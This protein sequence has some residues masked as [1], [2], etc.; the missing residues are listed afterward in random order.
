VNLPGMPHLDTYD[1]VAAD[2]P[3]EHDNFGQ[4]KHGAA[5][6]SYDEMPL[7]SVEED[8]QVAGWWVW[9]LSCWIGGGW[10][11]VGMANG[12]VPSEQAK[13]PDL[14]RR[15][16]CSPD[17]VSPS[18][19]R[20]NCPPVGRRVAVGRTGVHRVCGSRSG[21]WATRA[22]ID[23]RQAA[24]A[25]RAR[26]AARTWAAWAEARASSRPTIT[27]EETGL[28]EWFQDLARASD[29]SACAAATG[30]A[31]SRR[32]C[33]SPRRA[34]RD[35]PRPALRPGRARRQPLLGGERRASPPTFAPGRSST[36]RTSTSASC[37]AA[38]RASTTCPRAGASPSGTRAAATRAPSAASR[39]ASESA[40]GSRPH[41]YLLVR[42]GFDRKRIESGSLWDADHIEARVYGGATTLANARTLCVPCH[43][44]V[45]AELAR[46][47]AASRRRWR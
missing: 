31:S 34:D 22:C 29:A 11:A 39:T 36:A 43:R 40:C 44:S 9:G 13:K 41:A 18:V 35:R 19:W 37:S 38:T 27:R 30:S 45:T 12:E 20:K 33:S 24:R 47:R 42:A 32:R 5:K 16:G 10:C 23:E 1:I 46:S 17:V 4:A 7:E 25:D 21:T 6:A 3:W 2:V 14:G 8:P 26:G 15:E 28:V